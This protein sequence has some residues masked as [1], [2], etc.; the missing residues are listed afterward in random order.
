MHL[1]QTGAGDGDTRSE[2]DEETGSGGGDENGDE[3]ILDN[4]QC[5]ARIAARRIKELMS[6]DDEGRVFSVWD[7]TRGEYRPV[8]YR[9]IVILLRTTKNWSD[10]FTEE[11][12]L[13]G[14]PVFAETGSGF[15]MT[16]EV[17]VVL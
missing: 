11:L 16:I 3:E 7:K 14:I 1:I 6:P 13:M 5:E 9:D 10:V 4:I 12:R 15:F 2:A 8:T 17:Q